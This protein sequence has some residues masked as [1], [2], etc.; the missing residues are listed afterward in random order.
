M[1]ITAGDVNL[2]SLEGFGDARMDTPRPSSLSVWNSSLTTS[3]CLVED[4]REVV[5][6]QI[7]RE[8]RMKR[9]VA[10]RNRAA[11]KAI[12]TRGKR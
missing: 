5:N 7:K 4:C 11:G 9:A 3:G 2:A 6:V 8:E 1:F 10:G 12:T